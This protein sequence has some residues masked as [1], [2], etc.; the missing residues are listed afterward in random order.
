MEETISLQEIFQ[1]LRK[2]ILLIFS[3][4]FLAASFS[5][6]LSYFY[7]TPI[8]ETSTQLLINQESTEQMYGGLKCYIAIKIKLTQ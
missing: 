5:G 1:T 7:I 3:I 6:V 4:T 8:Y 2:R